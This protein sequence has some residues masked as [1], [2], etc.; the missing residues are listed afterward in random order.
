MTPKVFVQP[1]EPELE[2][3]LLALADLGRNDGGCGQDVTGSE[4]QEYQAHAGHVPGCV[5]SENVDLLNKLVI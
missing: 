3:A 5:L 2:Q 4:N 1:R